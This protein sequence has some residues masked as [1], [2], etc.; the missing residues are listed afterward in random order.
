MIFVPATTVVAILATVVVPW[1]RLAIVVAVASFVGYA[2]RFAN[3]GVVGV[4]AV[5]VPHR[6]RGFGFEFGKQVGAAPGGWPCGTVRPVVA[7]SFDAFVAKYKKSS[8]ALAIV[9]PCLAIAGFDPPTVIVLM[10]NWFVTFGPIYFIVVV[11]VVWGCCCC[12]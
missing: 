12:C 1:P 4:V 2:V 8:R 7:P 11:V 10:P 9:D 3:R 5:T 6:L